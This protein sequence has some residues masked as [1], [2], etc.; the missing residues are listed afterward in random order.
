MYCVIEIAITD[1]CNRL[2]SYCIAKSK[3]SGV[4]KEHNH[5]PYSYPI[6]D[7]GDYELASGIINML[8][9]RKWLAVQ[10]NVVGA[11]N[12]Q[13]VLTGGEPTLVRDIPCLIEWA[14]DEGLP[15]PILF[16]NGANVPDLAS[17][18]DIKRKVKI[19][20]TKHSESVPIEHLAQKNKQKFYDALKFI[21]EFDIPHKVKVLIK[22]G[23]E[24]P[25]VPDGWIVEG[26]RYPFDMS[27]IDREMVPFGNDFDFQWRFKG[28]GDKIDRKTTKVRK[29]FIVSVLPTGDIF[30]CHI[31]DNPIGNIYD[32][33]EITKLSLQPSLCN[34]QRI[35]P[36][37]SCTDYESY[38]KKIVDA[39]AD[40]RC[41]LQ[42]YVNLNG[43]NLT[44]E[45]DL[46]I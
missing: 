17:V 25:D 36:D 38:I 5:A 41:E 15:P 3:R 14:S 43:R 10:K 46:Y 6:N 21:E 18:E 12:L 23:E 44:V 29:C 11:D 33:K 27:K 26:V 19:Y 37:E 35:F 1:N 45:K 30:N 20:L 13:L 42:H 34:E 4:I 39:G 8:A 40:T 7:M 16:T 31:Y 28:Y 24:K 2:C 9:L 32:L 22:L